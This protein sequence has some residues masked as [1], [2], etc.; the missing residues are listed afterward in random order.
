MLL[1]SLVA[2]AVL[3]GQFDADYAEHSTRLQADLLSGYNTNVPG[4]VSERS[5]LRVAL[6]DAGTDVKLQIR[7]FKVVNVAAAQGQMSLKVWYR[8]SWIDERLAWDESAYGGIQK[9]VLSTDMPQELWI[10]DVQPYNSLAPISETLEMADAI[11]SSDGSVFWSRP[12]TLDLI[13]KFSVML[14]THACLRAPI[15]AAALCSSCC[16]RPP[17]AALCAE[18]HCRASWRSRTTRSC[19]RSKSV[20]GRGP[21]P[22]RASR[23]LRPAPRRS[24]RRR[25]RQARLTRS[26]L[27]ARSL[28]SAW[29]T[30][31][32]L[33]LPSRGPSCTTP[34]LSNAPLITTSICS[35]GRM[36]L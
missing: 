3:A 31:T 35:S 2:A 4:N 16:A 9:I 19:V 26:T 13:C 15:G 21:A 20:A 11:V 14:A 36:S 5:P 10:P 34:S 7:I 1:V 30:S 24:K 12:G 6:S 29:C 27:S 25:R 28:Q 23:H 33:R 8:L 22:T 32:R 18:R 17:I